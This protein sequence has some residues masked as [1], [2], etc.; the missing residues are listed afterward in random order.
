MTVLAIQLP[1]RE[2]LAARAAGYESAAGL[3][4]PSEWPFVTSDD[5]RSVAQ[6]GAVAASLLPRADRVV[7]LLAD[8]DVSWHRVAIPKA[9][10]ARMRA[11][12]LGSMEE[13]LL[14]DDEALHFALAPGAVAGQVGW[15]AV[16]QRTRLV[17][18]LAALEASGVRIDAVA[19]LSLPLPVDG[20]ASAAKGADAAAPDAAAGPL[21]GHFYSSDGGAPALPWLVLARPEGVAVLRL[22]GALA[23]ALVFNAAPT[24]GAALAELPAGR[25]TATPAA[26]AAAEQWLGAPVELLGEAERWLE[27]A[28]GP[29]DLRQFDLAPHHRGT[30][31][32]REVLRNFNTAAWRPV[33]FGLVALAAVMVLGLNL[34]AWQMERQITERRSAMTTLL[35][36]THPNVRAVL[37]APLQMQRE[38]ERLRA[39]AGRPGDGDLESLLGAAA[40]AWPDGTG[41]IQTLR[42]ESGSLILAA[43]GFGEPQITQFRDRLRGSGYAADFSEGRLTVTRAPA[44]SAGAP[45]T[46]RAAGVNGATPPTAVAPVPRSAA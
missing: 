19:P 37:D 1:P 14:D 39:S 33:R 45:G 36:T 31:A 35:Q 42:F 22:N 13:T 3:R 23:R 26:A 28:A 38:T 6:S 16:T 29:L 10:P 7:L 18:A 25:W 32:L 2:R 21:R 11:A 20:S 15:V 5:G 8:A 43:Q 12:L 34:Q 17:A 40:A 44:A 24:G 46:A 9:Q 27:A 4:I 41:P 30:R